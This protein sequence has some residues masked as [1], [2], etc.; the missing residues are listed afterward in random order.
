PG[1]GRRQALFPLLENVVVSLGN[2][3]AQTDCQ[4]NFR[5]VMNV[6]PYLSLGS[7]IFAHK[8]YERNYFLPG[9]CLLFRLSMHR[10][11]LMSDK[12]HDPVMDRVRDAFAASELSLDELGRK[13]GGEGETA[14]K[15][16]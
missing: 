2:R 16:A 13:M 14:R 6:V 15:A 1:R 12:T 3:S 10:L 9:F 7:T 5:S 4:R 11:L 8:L